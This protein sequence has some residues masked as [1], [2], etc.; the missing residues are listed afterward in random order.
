MTRTTTSTNDAT[1][2]KPTEPINHD[3]PGTLEELYHEKGLSLH[4]IADRSAVSH[5]TIRRRME[6]F[7]IKRRER[8]KSVPYANFRTDREGYERWEQGG[9]PEKSQDS[10]TVLV[11]RLVAVAEHGVDVVAGRVVHHENGIPWDNRPEN[12][13]IMDWGE[14]T[15][16]HN[17]PVISDEELLAELRAGYEGLGIAP[18]VG[19]VEAFGEY[20][21]QPYYQRFGGLLK[22]LQEAD[23]PLR[24]S[25][26]AQLG[27]GNE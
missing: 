8:A 19:D 10:I 4:Q 22:A 3:D 13:V 18:T 17:D 26:K 20:S 15:T 1:D 11:H 12:L 7:G 9:G 16:H 14:H 25:Q 23:I 5:S 6:Q 2:E 21:L 27:D 24:D